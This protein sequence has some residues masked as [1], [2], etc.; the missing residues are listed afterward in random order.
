MDYDRIKQ[1]R[2]EYISGAHYERIMDTPVTIYV[3]AI[4]MNYTLKHDTNFMCRFE[5]YIYAKGTLS[6]DSDIIGPGGVFP[7]ASATEVIESLKRVN[8]MIFQELFK[9]HNE[10]D[11]IKREDYNSDE[12][13]ETAVNAINWEFNHTQVFNFSQ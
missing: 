5:D 6:G 2:K 3:K 8:G 12:E 13:F 10:I 4:D 11:A 1:D 9:K 7:I